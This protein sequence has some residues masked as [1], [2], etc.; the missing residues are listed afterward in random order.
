MDDG[1]LG[2]IWSSNTVS[3]TQQSQTLLTVKDIKKKT[4]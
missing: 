3:D 1:F 4:Q 2:C